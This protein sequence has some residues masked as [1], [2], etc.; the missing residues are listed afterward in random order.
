MALNANETINDY[1]E[2]YIHIEANDTNDQR[3]VS[4]R[5]RV[6]DV[7]TTTL[8]G[9]GLGIPF[10]GNA[11]DEGAILV[12]R[13]AD[14]DSLVLDVFGSV[15]NFPATTVTSIYARELTAGGGGGTGD[16]T[17]VNT[18]ATDGLAG[19]ADSGDV[20]LRLHFNGLPTATIT[21][22]DQIAFTDATDS[23]TP[24]N[25][26]QAGLGTHMFGAGLDVSA[27]GQLG[28]DINEL[29]ALS[30]LAGADLIGVSDADDSLRDKRSSLAALAAHFAGTNL[31]ADADG[32]LS[33][34]GNGGGTGTTVAVN[35]GTDDANTDATSLT[36]GTED[37][38]QPRGRG[39]TRS[40]RLQR[41]AGASRANA[42]DGREP[43]RQ[44]Q[45]PGCAR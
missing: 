21:G 2:L 25:A 14:G 39:G 26:T 40:G 36:I 42:A 1:E 30:N 5:F 29:P 32:V 44:P 23:H 43:D 20:D 15:I 19:G 22:P 4:G 10:A 33:A 12:R 6:S 8:A 31:T 24:K 11:T 16:I 3:V 27:T 13:N 28:L 17:A 34:S 9:G 38:L 37:R 18:A 45:S 7:P 35:P 41:S